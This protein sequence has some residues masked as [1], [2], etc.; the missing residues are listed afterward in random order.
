MGTRIRFAALAIAGGRGSPGSG[1]ALAV[2]EG[3]GS[4]VAPKP[5]EFVVAF[6]ALDLQLDPHHSIYSAEAQ[7]FTAAYEGLF[8]YDP[9]SLDPVRAAC[10]SYNRSQDGKT[11][12]F[13]IRDEARWSDGSPLLARDFRDAWLRALDPGDQGRLRRVLRRHRGRPRLPHGQ[14][15]RSLEGRASR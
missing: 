10:R 8:S 1:P 15:L 9:N 3:P 13:Y 14:D 6:N 4:E 7:I 2:A 11:Y 12:T 5:E